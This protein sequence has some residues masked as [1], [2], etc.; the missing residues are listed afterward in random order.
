MQIVGFPH[1][2]AQ[3]FQL[4]IPLVCFPGSRDL[5]SAAPSCQRQ[6]RGSRETVA[7]VPSPDPVCSS[8]GPSSSLV[9]PRAPGSW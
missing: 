2:A 9:L 8:S 3:I 5:N 6:G 7:P 1:E 4:F